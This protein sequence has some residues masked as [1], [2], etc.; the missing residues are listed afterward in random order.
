[1]NPNDTNYLAININIFK[2]KEL[3]KGLLTNSTNST[4]LSPLI[5]DIFNDSFG[6]KVD[7]LFITQE[8]KNHA[9]NFNMMISRNDVRLSVDTAK[10]KHIFLYNFKTDKLTLDGVSS[11]DTYNLLFIH[12][13]IQI[14]NDLEKNKLRMY[15]HRP[16][17]FKFNRS[18]QTEQKEIHLY[19]K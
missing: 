9:I 14:F 12:Y 19:K 11:N 7:K 16:I 3:Q 15:C 17:S 6:R 13:I 1:M 8:E 10:A 18:T 4:H 2:T 5:K